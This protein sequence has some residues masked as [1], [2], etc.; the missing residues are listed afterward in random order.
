MGTQVNRRIVLAS[1]PRGK[2]GPECYREDREAVPEPADA[3]VVVRVRWLSI[4]PTIRGWMERD[5][6][7]PAIPVGDVIRSGGAGEVLASRRDD[8]PIG[9]RVFGMVGWQDYAVLGADTPVLPIPEGIS[10]EDALSVYGI[11][12][13][14]A[15]FGLEDIGKPRAGET[16]VVSGAA[17]G[18]GSIAGQIAKLRGCRVV[19]IAGT[20]EKCDWVVDELGFDAC[21]NY[22]TEDVDARLGKLCPD[23]IDVYFDNVGGEILDAAL[24]H[25]NLHARIPLCGAISTYNDTEVA[26][27]LR[28]IRNLISQR[29]LMQGFIILDYQERFLEAILQLGTWV[30]DGKLVSRVDVV[31]G[32]SQAPAG[33]SRLFDGDNIGKVLVAVDEP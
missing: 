11:T 1:R 13:L 26:S 22:R 33:L 6:Y 3:E 9:T 32:L 10:Y 28:N 2:P 23:G 7:L 14:T 20:D 18:V 31:D 24:A 17:G 25:I 27:G 16:V 5:T 30:A 21:I 19:G 12:G 15:Y 8:I 4:D 29:G